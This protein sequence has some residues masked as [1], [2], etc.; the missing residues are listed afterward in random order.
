MRI[1][2]FNIQH[3]LDYQK[4]VIDIDLFVGSIKK[5]NPD[6]CGINEVRGEGPIE[7]YTD[8]TNAIG[9]GLGF[10]RYFGQAIMV[11]GTS[12]YGNAFVSRYPIKSAE[13]VIIPDTDDRSE[14]SNYETRCVI[15]AVIDVD[16]AEITFLVCHMGLSNAERINAVKTVC[17]LIDEIETPLVLMGDFNTY[18]EDSVLAPLYDRLKDTDEKADVKGMYTYPSYNPDIKIDYIFYRGLKCVGAK[19]VTEIISDHFPIVA[20]FDVIT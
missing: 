3:A 8:Q 2:T 7:G 20:D 11:K 9:D 14:V 10:Q 1:M 13:T 17:S 18:P 15:K 5:F 6:F 12:P 19:T 16:G 4:Q